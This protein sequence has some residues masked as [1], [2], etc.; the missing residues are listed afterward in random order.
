MQLEVFTSVRMGE[1]IE[2][3]S[4]AGSGRELRYR[5]GVILVRN[6]HRT[7]AKNVKQDVTFSCF[8]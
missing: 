8:L 1:Y 5:G 3:T 4:R 7:D 6:C 2:S